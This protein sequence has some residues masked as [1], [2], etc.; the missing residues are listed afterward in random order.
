MDAREAVEETHWPLRVPDCSLRRKRR[1]R[2]PLVPRQVVIV[3][4]SSLRIQ[5]G[6]RVD[7][8]HGLV[9]SEPL[10]LRLVQGSRMLTRI[11]GAA[12]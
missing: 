2:R 3:D 1:R 9:D 5:L 6:Q 4:A 7:L 10:E 8:G 12:L 11:D